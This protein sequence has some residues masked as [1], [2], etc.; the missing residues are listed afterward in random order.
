MNSIELENF[1]KMS[2][3]AA[4]NERR[5]FSALNKRTMLF[6]HAELSLNAVAEQWRQISESSYTPLGKRKYACNRY[7]FC[8][9]PSTK[10]IVRARC[11]DKI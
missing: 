9:H 11:K 1:I 10:E 6:S 7:D 4:Y 3:S 2:N 5:L 8:S